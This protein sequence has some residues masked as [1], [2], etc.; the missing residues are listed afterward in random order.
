MAW[1][2][3]YFLNDSRRISDVEEFRSVSD[4]EA[5]GQAQSL[6]TR[7]G[8]F[9]GFELWQGARPIWLYPQSRAA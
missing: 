1:Y 2:R 5:L 4:D 7:R 6:L 8:N 9:M 3:A